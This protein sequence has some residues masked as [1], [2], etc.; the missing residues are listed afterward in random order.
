[1]RAIAIIAALLCAFFVFYTTRLLA[2]THGLQ[3]VR[4]TGHGAYVGAV[5]FPLLALAFG[6]ASVRAWQAA[7]RNSEPP[8]S[9]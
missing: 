9:A 7:R 4:A 3:Q 2:V 6:W 5:I 1:M 8:S